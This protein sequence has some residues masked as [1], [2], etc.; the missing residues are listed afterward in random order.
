MSMFSMNGKFNQKEY[1]SDF[2]TGNIIVLLVDDI[3]RYDGQWV[4]K[5]FEKDFDDE[6]ELEEDVNNTTSNVKFIISK[7]DLQ[8]VLKNI[9]SSADINII[10]SEKIN[11]FQKDVNLSK[12]DQIKIIKALSVE[13][14]VYS[15]LSRNEIYKGSVLTIFFPKLELTVNGKNIK[16]LTMCI[17][18]DDSV[19]GKI[20]VVSLHSGEDVKE[21]PHKDEVNST[22][23]V[24]V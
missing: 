10:S 6:D 12:E 18:I 5:E 17:K 14:Y 13:D 19:A 22:K 7:E 8:Q 2:I 20:V 24:Q 9:S 11:K 23:E 3:D 15:T 1:L 4:N 16:S 21:H